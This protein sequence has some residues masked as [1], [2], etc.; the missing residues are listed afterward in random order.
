MTTAQD[1]TVGGQAA[2]LG[3][4]SPLSA[5]S[6]QQINSS[7]RSTL[8][9]PNVPASSCPNRITTPANPAAGTP[10][11]LVVN[12]TITN[13]TG[14]TLTTIWVRITSLTEKNGPPLPSSGHAW[15]RLVSSTT[16]TYPNASCPGAQSGTAQGVTVQGPVSSS[17]GG[18]LGTTV[19]VPVSLAN[20]S[21]I[22]IALAF[23]IDQ[24]G[25]FSFSYDV[26][27]S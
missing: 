5:T 9:Q 16:S 15:L 23:D 25:S 21:S 8:F 12:R 17:L 13:T 6:P 24:G 18:G 7:V 1:A 3:S 2:L 20:N 14:K 27:A 11:R 19:R 4:P 10:A 22:R 26:D